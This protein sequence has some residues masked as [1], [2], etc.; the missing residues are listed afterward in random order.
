MV[1]RQLVEGP[2]QPREILA[3]FCGADGEAEPSGPGGEAAAGCSGVA[4]RDEGQVGDPGGH[5]THAGRFGAEGLDHLVRHE[6]GV[7]V[8]PGPPGRGPG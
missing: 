5:D 8:D 3:R 1:T 7:G 2:H 6:G 4:L